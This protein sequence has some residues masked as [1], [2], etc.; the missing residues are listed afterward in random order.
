MLNRLFKLRNEVCCFLS[1]DASLL[2]PLFKDNEW[3]G[4][5]ACLVDIFAKLNDLNVR[6]S[7]ILKLYDRVNGFLKK[8][9]NCGREGDLHKLTLHKLY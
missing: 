9:W 1:E 2:A 7:T 5:L 6:D 4:K 3:L 8:V